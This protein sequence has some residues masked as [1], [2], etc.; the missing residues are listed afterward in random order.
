M[1]PKR[2]HLNKGEWVEL[3]LPLYRLLVRSLKITTNVQLGYIQLPGD[4]KEVGISL[5]EWTDAELMEAENLARSIAA[6]IIDLKINQV[7]SMNDQRASELGRICQDTVIDR[8]IP[9]L[10]SWPGRGGRHTVVNP[11]LETQKK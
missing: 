8:N 10:L 3:Q 6:D 11:D 7:A 4:L 9:W 2:T 1:P 5:A